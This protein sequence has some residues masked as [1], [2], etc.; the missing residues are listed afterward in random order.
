MKVFKTFILIAG[1]KVTLPFKDK[2]LNK[3]AA[4]FNISTFLLTCAALVQPSWFR[5]KG[6]HCTQSLSLTQFFTFDEDDD[7]DNDQISIHQDR[8][9]D[10]INRSDFNGTFH[11]NMLSNL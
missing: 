8:E 7:D 9:Y 4:F 1:L 2:E 6:L 3:I 5:I 10:P 11:Q